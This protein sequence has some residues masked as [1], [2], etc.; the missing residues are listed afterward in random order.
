LQVVKDRNQTISDVN[1]RD[2]ASIITFDKINANSP[3]VARTLT[4]NYD[5]VMM[6]CT[7]LQACG[8][9]GYSTGTEAGMNLAYDHIKP[10]SQG[11]VGRER[12]NKIVVLLTDGQPNLKRSSMT[13][14]LI[15]SYI[16]NNPSTWTDPNTNQEVNNWITTGSLVAEKNASLMH[17]SSMQ[18]GNGFVYAA[19]VGLGCDYDF[20]DRMARMGGTANNLGQSPRGS[21]DPAV[22]EQRMRQIFEDI[23]TNPKLRLVQ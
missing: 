11:G 7:Q 6:A 18:A 10:Q 20:M 15:N 17:A 14:S 5:S 1:Q 16:S 13:T 21:G 2:W 19:G 22:Y 9:N 4:D 3:T 12:T 23:L 8:H